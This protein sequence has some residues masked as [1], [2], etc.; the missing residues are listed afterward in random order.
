MSSSN[1]QHGVTRIASGPG[2]RPW[3][4]LGHRGMLGRAMLERLST[5]QIAHTG[6]DREDIDLT[7][8][9]HVRDL[10]DGRWSVVVNCAAWTDVDGAEEN[11][12]AATQING[13]GVG[14]IAR[15]CNATGAVLVH[16]STDYVFDGDAAEPYPV[17]APRQPIGAYGRSKLAG[18]LAIES[19][20]CSHI[21]ARTSWLYAPWGK[22]FVR[23]IADLA[24]Q[25]P[26]LK[27]VADQTG[28]PTS[29]Q[30]LADCLTRLVE[31][32]ATGTYHVTDGGQCTWH[33][34]AREIVRLTGAA[35][36]VHPCTTAEFPRPAQRPAW[37][38]LDLTETERLLGPMGS[39][40]QHLADVLRE[41]HASTDTIARGTTA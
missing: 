14:H 20:Q 1:A 2:S 30:H 16:V 13:S 34:F 9:D 6:V 36:D 15:A 37:S 4:V 8:E 40:Q 7:D 21:I 19:E 39:W 10:I 24:S 32:G 11:E 33:E 35:C 17:H 29:A 31:L 27:V 26:E 23:T 41:I 12:A 5:G 38:V 28:R 3:L 25:R 22:N 18:E